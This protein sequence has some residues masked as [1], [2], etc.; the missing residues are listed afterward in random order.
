MQETFRQLIRYGIAG[1]ANTALGYTVI[2]VLMLVSVPPVL[3]NLVGYAAGLVLAFV[4][5]KRWVFRSKADISREM[6][7]FLAAFVLCYLANL[8]TL[9]YLLHQT[10]VSPYLAQAIAGFVY[11]IFFFALSRYVVFES[12]RE[13]IGE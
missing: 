12:N 2:Y 3:S 4:L 8:G 1:S 5:Q 7:K 13:L 9:A 10:D 6:A 11:L